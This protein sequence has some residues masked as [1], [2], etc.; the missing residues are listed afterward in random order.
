LLLA[1][2]SLQQVVFMIQHTTYLS[3]AKLDFLV[4]LAWLVVPR[5]N[6][7]K[8]EKHQQP[9]PLVRPHT[10]VAQK[11]LLA[12]RLIGSGV[13]TL[14]IYYVDT[15]KKKMFFFHIFP[16]PSVRQAIAVFSSGARSPKSKK[17]ARKE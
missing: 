10:R 17:K 4:C 11:Q 7:E 8:E 1:G 9:K 14:I 13:T 2:A 15:R 5:R 6:D 12:E 3:F 16:R